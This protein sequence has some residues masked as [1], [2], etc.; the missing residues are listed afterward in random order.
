MLTSIKNS[1]IFVFFENPSEN[2]IETK[3]KILIIIQKSNLFAFCL[4][5]YYGVEIYVFNAFEY[6]LFYFGIGL[7]KRS[8]KFL[9]FLPFGMILPVIAGRTCIG[10]LTRALYK[11]KVVIISP[12]FYVVFSYKIHRTDKFHSFE[13]SAF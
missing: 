2:F 1:S 7:F 12:G 4:I 6:A 10:E 5:C 9:Y 11:M 8:Y 13:V 3:S